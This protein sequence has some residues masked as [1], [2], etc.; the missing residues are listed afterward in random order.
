M[1]A[2]WAQLLARYDAAALRAPEFAA[3]SS[4]WMGLNSAA[5]Q[6]TFDALRRWCLADS[7]LRLAVAVL[8]NEAPETASRLALQLALERDGSWQLSNC[9]SAFARLQL[10]AITKLR[11]ALTTWRWRT[12]QDADPWDSGHLRHDPEGLRALNRFRP[13]RA[14]LIVADGVPRAG[15]QAAWAAL[16]AQHA[17]YA[18]PVRL[19][20]V[21]PGPV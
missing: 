15:L 9:H 8:D 16:Q 10:R 14:T 11:D 17:D 20:V 12:R 4:P 21:G 6:A 13:R 19:L 3:Q 18:H 7:A 1:T 2:A 5:E